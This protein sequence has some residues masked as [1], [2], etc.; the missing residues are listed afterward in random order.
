MCFI[1]F[2]ALDIFSTRVA[3]GA[4]VLAVIGML[5]MWQNF[6]FGITADSLH[7]LFIGVVRGVPQNIL[8]YCVAY[9]IAKAIAR[10]ISRLMHEKPI[11]NSSLVV[12]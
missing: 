8:M 1:L 3:S 2:A 9:A 5:N 6:L 4:T 10:L 12:K 11:G 7:H